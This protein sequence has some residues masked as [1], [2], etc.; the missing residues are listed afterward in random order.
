[1][2]LFAGFQCFGR[3]GRREMDFGKRKSEYKKRQR[4]CLRHGEAFG[5]RNPK[6]KLNWKVNTDF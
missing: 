3:W 4:G 5:Y 1:M 2:F 6:A